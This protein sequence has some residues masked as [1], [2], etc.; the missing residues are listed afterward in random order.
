MKEIIELI[1]KIDR[2]QYLQNWLENGVIVHIP[3][4]PA[5]EMPKQRQRYRMKRPKT[6]QSEESLCDVVPLD[7]ELYYTLRGRLNSAMSI[8]A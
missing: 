2:E 6:A 1:P 5:V 7:E 8:E 3:S 4:P